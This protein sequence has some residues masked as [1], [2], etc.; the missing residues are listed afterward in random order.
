[1][2]PDLNGDN[3]VAGI[4]SSGGYALYYASRASMPNAGLTASG[5]IYVSFAGYTEDIDDEHKYLDIHT[6]Q[7]HKMEE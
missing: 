2:A 5:D 3:Q 1:M 4:D 7:D 6:S